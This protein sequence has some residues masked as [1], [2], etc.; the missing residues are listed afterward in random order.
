MFR[1]PLLVKLSALLTVLVYCLL[2]AKEN[3]TCKGKAKQTIK[4]MQVALC[5]VIKW[6]ICALE[7]EKQS[8]QQS[9][10]LRQPSRIIWEWEC[11]QWNYTSQGTTR[12][13]VS[14][15]LIKLCLHWM[16]CSN[17][18]LRSTVVCATRH[19]GDRRLGDSGIGWKTLQR[20]GW[21]ILATIPS[22]C[23]HK[24]EW[25]DFEAVAVA[26]QMSAAHAISVSR[27]TDDIFISLHLIWICLLLL[28]SSFC[29][30]DHFIFQGYSPVGLFSMSWW[31]VIFIL[32]DF[33]SFQHKFVCHFFPV[34]VV[35]ESVQVIQGSI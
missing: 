34:V 18:W 20:Q 23:T 3:T 12:E 13:F 29:V 8:W 32:Y 2:A 17:I 31:L 19:L 1:P 14:Q 15:S 6:N 22:S 21:D 28:F 10:L 30:F 24:H 25:G 27:M 33:M 11:I 4:N 7:R 16:L 5:V 9:S 35:C 26:N